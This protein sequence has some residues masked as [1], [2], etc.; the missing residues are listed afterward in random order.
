MT[1]PGRMRRVYNMASRR[2]RMKQPGVIIQ[3]ARCGGSKQELGENRCTT[4][5]L[6]GADLNEILRALL[7]MR[8][9]RSRG[10]I[11]KLTK[12]FPQS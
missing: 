1:L 8:T 10:L 7:C 12:A 3:E 11:D 2:W 5:E 9:P 6:S 4:V